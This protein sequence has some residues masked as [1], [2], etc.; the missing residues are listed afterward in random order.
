[1]AAKADI[2]PDFLRQLLD[3]DPSTGVF[4]WR[5]RPLSMFRTTPKRTAEHSRAIWNKRYAGKV[6]SSVTAYGYARIQIFQTYYFAHRI[7]WMLM[8]HQWPVND[9]DHINGNRL[10]NRISNLRDATRAENLQNLKKSG[11]GASGYKGAHW[12]SERRKWKSSIKLHGVTHHLGYFSSKEEAHNAY[13]K[14]KRRL[15]TFN[16]KL[17]N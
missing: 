14:A 5:E 15:H 12:N 13:V 10:D 17:R 16:R 11:I 8:K 4:H 1:M 6:I 7:A 2:T 3:Y 9:I